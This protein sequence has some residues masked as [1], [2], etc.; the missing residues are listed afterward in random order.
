[1]SFSIGDLDVDS[2]ILKV[3][4][5]FVKKSSPIGQLE[6]ADSIFEIYTTFYGDQVMTVQG[7]GAGAHVTAGGVYTDL[8]RIG[9]KL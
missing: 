9:R 3:S 4:L 1:M 7:T 5:S 2:M 8:L 6:N